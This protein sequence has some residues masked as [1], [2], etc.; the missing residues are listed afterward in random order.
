MI[1]GTKACL[2]VEGLAALAPFTRL[3]H[4]TLSTRGLNSFDLAAPAKQL[5]K[6]RTFDVAEPADMEVL[7]LQGPNLMVGFYGARLIFVVSFRMS[8]CTGKMMGGD[9]L[10]V[11]VRP[12]SKTKN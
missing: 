4:L 7:F 8:R 1:G 12:T 2:S 6:L 5:P 9:A 3:L 11:T 10:L